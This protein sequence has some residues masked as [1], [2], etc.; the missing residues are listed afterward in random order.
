VEHPNDR[1]IEYTWE[2]GTIRPHI[3]RPEEGRDGR[4]PMCKVILTSMR[5]PTEEIEAMF[6]YFDEI[7]VICDCEVVFD[8]VK[9]P[10]F[11]RTRR[12]FG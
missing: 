7:G 5:I 2:C 11:K 12:L 9:D 4:F 6:D 10:R 3:G 8:V 1:G